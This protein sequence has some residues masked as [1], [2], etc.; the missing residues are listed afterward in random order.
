ML[1]PRRFQ[2]QGG[3][4]APEGELVEVGGAGGIV[5]GGEQGDEEIA[6]IRRQ[7]VAEVV[8]E[9]VDRPIPRN[10]VNGPIVVGIV[11]RAVSNGYKRRY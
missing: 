3:S 11:S 6:P 2:R 1:R 10:S 5:D 7:R 8:E 9:I 4:V